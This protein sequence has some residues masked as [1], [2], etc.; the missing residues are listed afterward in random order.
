[1]S[2]EPIRECPFCGNEGH[3]HPYGAKIK[4]AIMEHWSVACDACW[5]QCGFHTSEERAIQAWNQRY[6]PPI[7]D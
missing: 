6:A 1:M 3:Q 4:G 7:E 2:A 5:S